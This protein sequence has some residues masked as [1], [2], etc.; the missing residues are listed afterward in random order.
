MVGK[1]LSL[2]IVK[3]RNLSY[4]RVWRTTVMRRLVSCLHRD[5][6]LLFKIMKNANHGRG[7][8]PWGL[9]ACC[10]LPITGSTLVLWG[11]MPDSPG[12]WL[13]LARWHLWSMQMT[14][15]GHVGTVVCVGSESP[16][17]GA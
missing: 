2:S 11:H 7:G 4:L 9:S 10:S 15:T 16:A 17:M 12:V 3:K 5:Q 6:E 8:F 14:A 13:W 1:I